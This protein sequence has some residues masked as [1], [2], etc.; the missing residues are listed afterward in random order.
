MK[1]QNIIDNANNIIK[2]VA[3]S[4]RSA[5]KEYRT[6]SSVL[7]DIQ[8][9]ALLKAGYKDVFAAVGINV[10][11]QKLTPSDFF[12]RLHASQW[13]TDKKG[14][15]FVGVWGYKKAEDGTKQPVLRKVTSWTPRKVFVVLAQSIEAAK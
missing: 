11:E 8:R 2:G 3:A 14:E 5:D 15:K 12:A 10:D 4:L 9:S 1:T 7:K 6:I 13:D